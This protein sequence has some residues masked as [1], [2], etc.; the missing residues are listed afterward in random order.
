MRWMAIICF[1]AKQLSEASASSVSASQMYLSEGSTVTWAGA[2]QWSSRQGPSAAAI[3]EP[4]S[5]LSRTGPVVASALRQRLIDPAALLE[6]R[7]RII[8]N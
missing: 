7:P 3:G 6:A 5:G 2:A 1:S 8:F 4:L